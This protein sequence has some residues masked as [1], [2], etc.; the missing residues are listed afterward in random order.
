MDVFVVIVVIRDDLGELLPEKNSFTQILSLW[1]L[2]N[3]V[4]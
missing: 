4:N 3:K 1:M 2:Y